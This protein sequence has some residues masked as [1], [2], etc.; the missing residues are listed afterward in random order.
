MLLT[1]DIGN[2]NIAYGLFDNDK[3][4]F[5]AKVATEKKMT[6]DQHAITLSAVAQMNKILL[7]D[8]DGAIISSVVPELTA[9]V[10]E[11]ISILTGVNA[12][13]LGPGVKSG[14]PIR[15]DNPAQLGADL[16]AGAVGALEMFKPPCLIIDLGTATKISVIDSN[17]AYKGCT[18][19]AG[20]GISLSA[21]SGSAA[22]LPDINIELE[23]CTAFGTNTVASMQTGIVLG[24]AA[25][26]DGMCSRIEE[27][28]G[29]AVKSVVAT[30]GYASDI[31]K[32]CKRK[33]SYEPDIVFYG[34]K[35]I[36]E[37][38]T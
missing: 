14:L 21:L 12:I 19:S 4:V 36:F 6:S 1:V 34:L 27:S 5:R 33:I 20:V 28:L 23:K 38:N 31:I 3:I 24:T 29:V 15:I 13:V 32:Y 17:G 25:M 11:A 22:L 30:G 10:K 2:T 26:I 7:S 16:V 8:V 35:T 37:K 18:I 9:H